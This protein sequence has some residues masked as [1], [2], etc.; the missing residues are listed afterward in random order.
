MPTIPNA[1]VKIVPRKLF[2]YCENG[3]TQPIIDAATSAFGQ[4]VSTT[5]G[6]E[7]LFM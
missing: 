3:V 1:P 4:V 5:N 7:V 6:G 2:A